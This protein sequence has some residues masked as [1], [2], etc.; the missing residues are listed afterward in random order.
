MG[1]LEVY[2][3]HRVEAMMYVMMPHHHPARIFFNLIALPPS[4]PSSPTCSHL[5]PPPI[6]TTST[7]EQLYAHLHAW[8]LAVRLGAGCVLPPGIVRP[9]PDTW[10]PAP[11]DAMLNVNATV[12]AARK[13]Y[14]AM[15][16]V[17]IV[18]CWCGERNRGWVGCRQRVVLDHA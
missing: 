1:V 11:L 9:R 12:F 4:P 8:V 16:P 6:T 2:C 17:R 3:V 15:L 10:H 14:L 7:T 5:H 13:L 18:L